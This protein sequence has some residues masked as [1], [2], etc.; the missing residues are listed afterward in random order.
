MTVLYAPLFALFAGLNFACLTFVHIWVHNLKIYC[1]GPLFSNSSFC[2][3]L[4]WSEKLLVNKTYRPTD[5]ACGALR[6]TMPSSG[7]LSHCLNCT[8]EEEWELH[9]TRKVNQIMMASCCAPCVETCGSNIPQSK[10]CVVSL[11]AGVQCSV[12][13]I[14]RYRYRF[15]CWIT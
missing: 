9:V 2:S 1:H 7:C 4:V 14:W 11:V 13:F 12:F 15:C 8:E 10:W 3:N 5:P 6:S